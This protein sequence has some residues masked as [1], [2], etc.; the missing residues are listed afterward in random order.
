MSTRQTAVEGQF[1]PSNPDEIHAM[2]EHY[3]QIL[4][5]HLKDGVGR[6]IDQ[7]RR[8]SARRIRN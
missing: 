8:R 5:T 7:D 3:N 4:D 2:L 1:Y 6:G